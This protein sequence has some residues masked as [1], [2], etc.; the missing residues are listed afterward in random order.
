MAAAFLWT[1]YEGWCEW[2]PWEANGPDIGQY[3]FDR[4]VAL[5]GAMLPTDPKR[6]KRV[7]AY[8]RFTARAEEHADGD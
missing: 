4:I 8:E 2:E 6:K 3:D 7:A 1:A 5:M